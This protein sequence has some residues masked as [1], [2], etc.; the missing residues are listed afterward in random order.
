MHT[1]HWDQHRVSCAD[2]IGVP[3]NNI[4]KRAS[5]DVIQLIIGVAVCLK[6]TIPVYFGYTGHQYLDLV[7]H[8]VDLTLRHEG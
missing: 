4:V 2:G 5:H 8:A 6:Y 7:A 3:V 1:V